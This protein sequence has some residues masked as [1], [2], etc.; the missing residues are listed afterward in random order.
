V[1]AEEIECSRSFRSWFLKKTH[2]VDSVLSMLSTAADL[3]VAHGDGNGISRALPIENKIA[4]SFT[5]LQPG[6]YRIRRDRGN[7]DWKSERILRQL[8]VQAGWIQRSA[9]L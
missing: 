6:R 2:A 4:A 9:N 5:Q 7:K 1:L 3:L 8:D